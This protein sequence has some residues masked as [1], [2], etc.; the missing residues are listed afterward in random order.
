LSEEEYKKEYDRIR[1]EL[2]AQGKSDDE[3]D[4]LAERILK[5]RGQHHFRP[6]KNNE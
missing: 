4:A 6:P 2:K 1:S 3:A 5:L